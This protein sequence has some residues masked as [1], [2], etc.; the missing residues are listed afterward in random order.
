MDKVTSAF[1][2]YLMTKMQKNN[3]DTSSKSTAD[4]ESKDGYASFASTLDTGKNEKK[5]EE[6]K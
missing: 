2:N 5:K 1:N 4:E 6:L 3:S